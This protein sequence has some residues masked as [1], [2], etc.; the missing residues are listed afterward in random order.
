[1]DV[2]AYLAM[3]EEEGR[4]LRTIF[5]RMHSTLPGDANWFYQEIM[6]GVLDMPQTDMK[7]RDV[8]GKGGCLMPIQDPLSMF[9]ALLER[10]YPTNTR[11]RAE[12]YAHFVR[13]PTERALGL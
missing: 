10:A 2:K 13:G 5:H 8:E 3:W 1:M 4:S 12:E 6:D 11:E 9:I 7:G